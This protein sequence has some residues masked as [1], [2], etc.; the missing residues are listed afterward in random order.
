MAVRIWRTD[1]GWITACGNHEVPPRRRPDIVDGCPYCAV[2][3][4]E[5]RSSGPG[6][7]KWFD[8]G[9]A[10]KQAQASDREQ[11]QARKAYGMGSGQGR[12]ARRK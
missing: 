11:A 7:S 10:K 8:G 5:V 9:V 3:L 12:R 2:E 4:E 1:T 6:T